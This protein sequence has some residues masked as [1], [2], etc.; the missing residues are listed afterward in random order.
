M[1]NGSI[2]YIEIE[3]AIQKVFGDKLDD[4][5]GGEHK[6]TP[7]PWRGATFWGAMMNHGRMA[8][9]LMTTFRARRPMSRK[10]ICFQTWCASM[11]LGDT[12]DLSL[13]LKL[14]STHISNNTED[15]F[16]ETTD[17]RAFKGKGNGKKGKGKSSKTYQDISRL[18]WWPWQLSGTS[19]SSSTNQNG[20][21]L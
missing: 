18:W 8:M 19:T 20:T 13:R 1:T 2:D 21:R 3:K 15:I 7:R 12:N 6:H 4:Q 10:R 17:R 5:H 16:L 9:S 14:W 11:K